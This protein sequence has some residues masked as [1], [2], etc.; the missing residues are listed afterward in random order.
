[1]GFFAVETRDE[2]VLFAVK[3]QEE[4]LDEVSSAAGE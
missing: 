1:V 2:V 3:D 4:L